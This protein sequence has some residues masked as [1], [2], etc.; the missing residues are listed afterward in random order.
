MCC[1]AFDF[2]RLFFA[3]KSRFNCDKKGLRAEYYVDGEPFVT[4]V[5]PDEPA[6]FSIQTQ[7][8]LRF[9]AEDLPANADFLKITIDLYIVLENGDTVPVEF[10]Q[11]KG[12]AWG[13]EYSF[14]L[15]ETSDG[16]FLKAV[17]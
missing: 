13:G 1:F 12:F 17:Q 6:L 15:A 2:R 7:V 9:F 3:R 8:K 5:T 16:M 10:P 14:I 11:N 4:T